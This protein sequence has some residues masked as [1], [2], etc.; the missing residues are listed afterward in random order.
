ML[1]VRAWTLEPDCLGSNPALLWTICEAS[2][3]TSLGFICVICK[4]EV[5]YFLKLWMLNE[6]YNH[7]GFNDYC[8]DTNTLCVLFSGGNFI[9]I[10]LYSILTTYVNL[11]SLTTCQSRKNIFFSSL[12]ELSTIPRGLHSGSQVLPSGRAHASHH[13]MLPV[14]WSLRK[15][16]VMNQDELDSSLGSSLGS[17]L[18]WL[19]D[20]RKIT[21]CIGL[22]FFFFKF[23]FN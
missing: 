14:G 7:A 23:L 5:R 19:C 1:P 22:G 11:D 9:Y 3:S 6:S 13:I 12:R 8:Y 18:L 16:H 10:Q 20:T 4:I 17:V 21:S 15:E 2:Y